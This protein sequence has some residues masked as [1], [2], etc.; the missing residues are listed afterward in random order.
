MARIFNKPN[1]IAMSI[2]AAILLTLCYLVMIAKIGPIYV[3][4]G[5]MENMQVGLIIIAGLIYFSQI[6]RFKGRS[7][8]TCLFFFLL[9]VI[10]VAREIDFFKME[11]EIP[12]PLYWLLGT[13]VGKAFF[14]VPALVILFRQLTDFSY[15]KTHKSFYLKSSTF[16]FMSL[17]AFLLIVMSSSFDTKRWTFEY[18]HFFEELSEVIAYCA[19]VAAAIFMSFDL[20]KASLLEQSS[21]E[22]VD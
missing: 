17:A 5:P 22:K 19:Y 9:S 21:D 13:H 2:I 1:T 11:G 7:R 15:Y 6:F 16:L 8:E 4:H 3:E 18:R 10:F 12:D 20:T 14:Y